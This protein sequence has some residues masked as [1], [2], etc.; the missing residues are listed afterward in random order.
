[1]QATCKALAVLAPLT[2]PP[3]G[4]HNDDV[5]QPQMLSAAGQASREPTTAPA[6]APAASRPLLTRQSAGKPPLAPSAPASVFS[7]TSPPYARQPWQPCPHGPSKLCG[8]DDVYDPLS[9]RGAG[10]DSLVAPRE[11]PTATFHEPWGPSHCMRGTPSGPTPS[12]LCTCPPARLQGQADSYDV[13]GPLTEA[14]R[15]ATADAAGALRKR[16]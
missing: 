14:M 13:L 2:P 6:A 11:G 4:S 8:I 15:C 7:H 12:D 16:G 9:V 3:L 10:A 1:M 5:G